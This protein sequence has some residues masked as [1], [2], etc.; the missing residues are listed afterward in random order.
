MKNSSVTV[1]WMEG[2]HSRPAAKLVLLA[3]KYRA[4]IKL[5]CGEQVANAGSIVSIL[6]LSAA[7]G[8]TIHLEVSGADEDQAMDAVV[9]VFADP[10]I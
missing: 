4:N 10:E 5:V 2:L 8:S 1:P 3:R 7:L 9:R 6:L